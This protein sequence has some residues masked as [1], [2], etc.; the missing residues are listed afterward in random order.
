VKPLGTFASTCYGPPWDSMNGTG[1]TAG[2]TDLR[3]AKPALIVAVD[4][5]V[6][7][8][9]R[10]LRI[11]PNPH[12]TTQPFLADDTG[13]A[14]QGNRIDFYVWQG[15]EKQLAWPAMKQVKVY[16]VG[17]GDEAPSPGDA[18]ASGSVS[19]SGAAGADGIGGVIFTEEQKAAA[20]KALLWVV[21]VLGG[22]GLA[23]VGTARATG[24]GRGV[25]A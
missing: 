12:G 11:E 23:L 10:L 15:R 19:V 21:L 5:D 8:L 2:G 22:A 18:A 1:V 4:P 6:I 13:G 9:G 7:P 14:I 25:A 20:V 16:D 3:P 24:I 17:K